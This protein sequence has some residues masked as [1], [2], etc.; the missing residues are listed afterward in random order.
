VKYLVEEL[1]ADVN[2]K[3]DKGYTPLHGAALMNSKELIDYLV[4][5]G[6][7]VKARADMIY[8]RNSDTDAAAEK[9]KGDSVADMANGP[10]E[11]NLQYPDIV[12]HL[13]NLGS[14]F[15][16]NCKAAQ[17]VQRTRADRTE[18]KP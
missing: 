11:W 1:K 2:S 12:D 6:A 7:D 8:G 14:E 13:I 15:A 9:G 3:D 18:R 17:C 10:R 16:D 4:S 5:K